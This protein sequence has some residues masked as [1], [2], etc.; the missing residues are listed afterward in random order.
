MVTKNGSQN[1]STR[2]VLM[3]VERVLWTHPIEGGNFEE[4]NIK[5]KSQKWLIEPI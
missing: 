4:R 2:I 1:L 3:K 5:D